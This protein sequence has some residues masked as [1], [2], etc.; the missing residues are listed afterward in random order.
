[1]V[2]G[3][4]LAIDNKQWAMDTRQLETGTNQEPDN[5]IMSIAYC[6][7]SLEKG[8]T[9]PYLCV[10]ADSTKVGIVLVGKRIVRGNS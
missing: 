3:T 9:V 2:N 6:Q 1:M 8:H 4:R 10:A 5:Y 7:L